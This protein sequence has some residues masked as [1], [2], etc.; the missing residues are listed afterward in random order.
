MNPFKKAR[1]KLTL[2]YFAVSLI[3]IFV[4]DLS[5]ITAQ[6]HSF[7]ILYNALSDSERR[8]LL[9]DL[10][11]KSL[12]EFDS[13]FIKQLLY[14]NIISVVISIGSSYFLSGVTLSP[15]KRMFDDHDEFV[16]D[17]SHELRTPLANIS[18]ELE[19]L[20]RT[21]TSVVSLNEEDKKYDSLK[22]EIDKM[23]RLVGGL[24]ALVKTKNPYTPLPVESI[25]LGDLISN[26]V[27]RFKNLAFQKSIMLNFKVKDSKTQFKSIKYNVETILGILIDNALKF[28][29]SGG[30]VTLFGRIENDHILLSVS[31][32]GIGVAH[33]KAEKIFN[34]FYKNDN[35]TPGTGLG[36]S[37]AKKLASDMRGSIQLESVPGKGS[38]FTL[39]LPMD[40]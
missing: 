10:L 13:E 14:L 37:I 22:F 24:L 25:N 39:S 16:Q 20:E 2:S 33:D 21:D 35:N 29:P 28:T 7:S 6:R 17:V 30:S 5:V 23:N 3:L 38:V 34:R 19:I 31:D 15:I 12:T 4:F 18:S 11:A 9:T 1:L 8:P 40:S 36:L 32:T 27:F 26:Q